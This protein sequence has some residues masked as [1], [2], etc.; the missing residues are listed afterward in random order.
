MAEGVEP[1]LNPENC[2]ICKLKFWKE[3]I[4]TDGWFGLI[5]LNW[6]ELEVDAI[7]GGVTVVDA[8]GTLAD[9][10]RRLFGRRYLSGEGFTAGCWVAGAKIGPGAEAK[11]VDCGLTDPETTRAVPTIT[12]SSFEPA[13]WLNDDPSDDDEEVVETEAAAGYRDRLPV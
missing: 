13:L 9:S 7:A 5:L 2:G 4:D 11:S 12:E 10:T 3:P 1:A 8:V 6:T